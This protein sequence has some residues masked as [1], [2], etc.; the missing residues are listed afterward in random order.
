MAL[1]FLTTAVATLGVGKIPKAP[2]TFGSL[3]AVLMWWA[4]FPLSFP[5]QLALIGFAFIAGWVATHYYEKWN[6]KHDPKEVV[7]DELIGMWITLL[8]ASPK[9]SIFIV[10]FLLFRLFDI[11]KP[12]PIGWVD[13]KVPGALGTILDDVIAGVFAY[14]V[15][16]LLLL[17]GSPFGIFDY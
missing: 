13:N 4:L 10:G 11:W 16:Q 17:Q 8:G 7:V 12:F 2:G 3:L 6:H 15:L 5:V 14:V 9:A 1:N